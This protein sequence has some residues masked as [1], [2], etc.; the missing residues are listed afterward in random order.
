VSC[1]FVLCCFRFIISEPV[2]SYCGCCCS[3]CC[4]V[5]Q[6]AKSCGGYS[7]VLSRFSSSA[8]LAALSTSSFLRIPTWLGTQ[9][10]VILSP[11][12]PSSFLIF[13]VFGF[14]VSF[15]SKAATNVLQNSRIKTHALYLL[16]QRTILFK[17]DKC[18][19]YTKCL[20]CTYC[21]F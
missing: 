11:S 2:C 8:F 20:L 6:F 7:L 19:I 9:S 15:L 4:T 13:R 21:V 14:F 10:S 1:L 12:Y 5:I 18:R 3:L 17:R 16:H